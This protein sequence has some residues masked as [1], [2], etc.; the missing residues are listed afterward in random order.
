MKKTLLSLVAVAALAGANSAFAGVFVHAGPVTVAVG[1]RPHRPHPVP[2]AVPAHHR[3]V[4]VGVPRPVVVGVPHP[5]PIIV[6][7]APGRSIS[8]RERNEIREEARELRQEVRQ[9]GN[10]VSPREQR[11]IREEARELNQEIRQAWRD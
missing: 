11:E 3:P 4:V 7:G 10:V 5:Q 9:A 6:G 1:G 8:P 2:V